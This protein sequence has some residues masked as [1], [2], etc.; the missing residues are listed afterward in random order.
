MGFRRPGGRRSALSWSRR[1]AMPTS[2]KQSFT[3]GLTW[4][5]RWAAP[6][7][8]G[9]QGP[10]TAAGVTRS[11]GSCCGAGGRL[12][13][14][15]GV[16]FEDRRPAVDRLDEVEQVI[17]P[18]Q[19][20]DG[21][22]ARKLVDLEHLLERLRQPV[23]EVGRVVPAPSRDGTLMPSAP[24]DAAPFC[25]ISIRIGGSNAPMFGSRNTSGFG[26]TVVEV[27]IIWVMSNVT[28]GH[29]ARRRQRGGGVLC[30][31]VVEVKHLALVH[32][33]PPWQDAQFSSNA[34]PASGPRG[35]WAG[36]H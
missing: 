11:L 21:P 31:G 33:A 35:P 20:G 26:S 32:L 18:G 17:R 29:G 10:M 13:E 4:G 2:Q 7:S 5:V 9:G 15:V 25:R 12:V 24:S 30:T 27:L 1:S 3:T 36:G 14:A 19:I 6:V 8:R 28:P 23:V 22:A 16:R 34:A